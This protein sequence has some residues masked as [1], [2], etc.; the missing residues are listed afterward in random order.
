MGGFLFI[1]EIKR[2][3]LKT[4]RKKM[5]EFIVNPYI[6]LRLEQGETMI[7]VVDQPFKQ[8]KLLLLNI[9]I[10]EVS[11]FVELESIDEIAEDDDRMMESEMMRTEIP[12]DV[13]F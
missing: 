3:F 9:P 13:E 2:L 6:S 11:A 4:P 7:Y 8:C 5:K 12:P 10:A 1:A